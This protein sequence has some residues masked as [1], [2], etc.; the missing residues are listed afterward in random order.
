MKFRIIGFSSNA[1]YDWKKR[2]KPK[3]PKVEKSIPDSDLCMQK[4]KSYKQANKAYRQYRYQGK[5]YGV[6]EPH[7]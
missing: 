7:V 4:G 2:R 3:A 6:T 1:N 5:P